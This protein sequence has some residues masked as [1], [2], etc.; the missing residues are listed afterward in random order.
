MTLNSGMEKENSSYGESWPKGHF[1][2]MLG[3]DNISP[4]PVGR[5]DEGG[6]GV[7]GGVSLGDR[8]IMNW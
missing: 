4:I 1:G 8:G 6:M 5:G 2:E 3:Y 7:E